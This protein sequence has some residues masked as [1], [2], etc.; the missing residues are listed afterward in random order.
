MDEDR[1]N[2][3]Y[4]THHSLRGAFRTSLPGLSIL[5]YCGKEYAVRDLSSGGIG[6]VADP[7]VSAAEGLVPGSVQSLTLCVGGKPYITQLMGK[8][9]RVT[10]E[11]IVAMAFEGLD[12]T[13]ELRLDKLV[14]EIQKRLIAK[15]KAED[16]ARQA[17]GMPA[18]SGGTDPITI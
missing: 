7:G 13:K 6:F 15:R 14:L 11:G 4:P 2:I 8:V 17:Q 5:L 9:V 1:F 12:R 3:I 16:A 10:L 18:T